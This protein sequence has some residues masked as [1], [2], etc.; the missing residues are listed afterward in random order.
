MTA[1]ATEV[2]DLRVEH[3]D[4]FAIGVARP[5]LSWRTATDQDGW[6]QTAYELEITDES[7]VVASFGPIT[8]SDSVLVDWPAE[9]LASGA[10]RSVRV[11]VTGDDGSLSDWSEPLDRRGRAARPVR[12]G[13]GVR[14]AR[15]REGGDRAPPTRVRRSRTTSPAPGST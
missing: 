12:L 11:R 13:S 6:H 7:E 15:R 9:P 1:P 8:T 2:V 4:P 10:R 3:R 14:V 5:R